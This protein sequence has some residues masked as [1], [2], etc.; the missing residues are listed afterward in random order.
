MLFIDNEKFNLGPEE[1]DQLRA[2][3]PEFMIKKR[4]VSI[5]YVDNKVSK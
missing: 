5:T 1:L 4:P 3:F 2:V